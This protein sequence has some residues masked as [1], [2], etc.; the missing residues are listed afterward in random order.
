MPNAVSIYSRKR[1]QYAVKANSNV[2]VIVYSDISDVEN[3]EN[4]SLLQQSV[5]WQIYDTIR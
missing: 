5:Q 1:M 2:N 3:L 4:S